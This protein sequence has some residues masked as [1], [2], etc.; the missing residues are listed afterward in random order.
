VAKSILKH[1][2]IPINWSQISSPNGRFIGM[3]LP[4]LFPIST[5]LQVAE[6]NEAV[7]LRDRKWDSL[8]QAPEGGVRQSHDARGFF[9]LQG[10]QMARRRLQITIDHHVVHSMVS[11]GEI[12]TSCCQNGS[13]SGRL[14]DLRDPE[15]LPC[16]SSRLH[17]DYCLKLV[18][19]REEALTELRSCATLPD[20]TSVNPCKPNSR[21]SPK[22]P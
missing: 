6:L 9:G 10:V 19:M 13:E 11:K 8:A 16:G 21:P 5:L 20:S 15:G 3:G 2:Q 22:S 17:Q 14:E 4:H 1:P 18:K 7:A 12:R